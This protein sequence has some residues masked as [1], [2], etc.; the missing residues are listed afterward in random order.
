MNAAKL[1]SKLVESEYSDWEVIQLFKT[2]YRID[3]IN[4]NDIDL[5]NYWSAVEAI[6]RSMNAGH[7]GGELFADQILDELIDAPDQAAVEVV[8]TDWGNDRVDKVIRAIRDLID[9]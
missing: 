6:N 1:L 8:G 7:A 9:L 3:D 4:R 5:D 2:A